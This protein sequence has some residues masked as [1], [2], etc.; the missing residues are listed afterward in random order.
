[1]MM[2]CREEWE[3]ALALLLLVFL[4]HSEVLN[5]FVVDSQIFWSNGETHIGSLCLQNEM[6]VAMRAIFILF[7]KFTSNIIEHGMVVAIV[8]LMSTNETSDLRREKH[9]TLNEHIRHRDVGKWI[10][11]RKTFLQFLQPNTI[12]MALIRGCDSTSPWH[13]AQS[14]HLLQH[15]E[16]IETWTF[17]ICLH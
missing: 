13:S 5:I 1:M 8:Y 14:N 10:P 6:I 2:G 7:I 12:S 15:C 4:K 17:F 16:R 11:F 3:R 9:S